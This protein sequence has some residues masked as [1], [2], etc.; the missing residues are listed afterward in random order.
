MGALSRHMLPLA[1]AAVV[2]QGQRAEPNRIIRVV[3]P[4]GR[5]LVGIDVHWR[6]APGHTKTDSE[7]LF[8][9]HKNGRFL[10]GGIRHRPA[11]VEM[12]PENPEIEVRLEPAGTGETPLPACGRRQRKKWTGTF[13]MTPVPGGRSETTCGD[14]GCVTTQQH[15]TG[16]D[17]RAGI[18]SVPP[19]ISLLPPDSWLRDADFVE[20]RSWRVQ[21]GR[22]YFVVD[23]TGRAADGSR[24]RWA[25]SVFDIA[26]YHGASE[27][28]AKHFDRSIDRMCYREPK[29]HR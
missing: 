28:A 12:T 4:S 17:F 29:Q 13:V 26:S 6:G 8:F 24:W 15:P 16:G 5:P 2:A 23:L 18:D 1:L 19:S 7:G 3:D 21:G 14:H 10:I 22:G 27:R 20:L 25:S 9:P 11:L